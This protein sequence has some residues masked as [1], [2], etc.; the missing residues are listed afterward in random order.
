MQW[1]MRDFM[2]GINA[3]ECK[4][5]RTE[6]NESPESSKHQLRIR[7]ARINDPNHGTIAIPPDC[8]RVPGPIQQDEMNSSLSRTRNQN[9][10]TPKQLKGSYR[11]NPAGGGV[12]IS[13]AL[14]KYVVFSHDLSAPVSHYIQLVLF[15]QTRCGRMENTTWIQK[16]PDSGGKPIQIL[17]GRRVYNDPNCASVSS[18][19]TPFNHVYID[20]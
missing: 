9:K 18:K 15:P 16:I 19:K 10:T 6:Q 11:L 4:I 7:I 1:K 2:N 20:V 14:L 5:A 13:A 12:I 3:Y 17:L 8:T